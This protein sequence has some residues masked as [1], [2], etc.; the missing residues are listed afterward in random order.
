M[1]HSIAISVKDPLRV[2]QVLAEI[3]DG[4]LLLFPFIPNSYVVLAQDERGT[5]VEV[6]PSE[7]EFVLHETDQTRD[8]FYS[9]L[10]TR[11]VE[12][13]E[14]IAVSTS[15]EQIEQIGS[16]EG[17]QVSSKTPNRAAELWLENQIKLELL[18]R[19]SF[20]DKPNPT[21]PEVAAHSS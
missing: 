21:Q 13:R 6:Y 4:H 18:P 8:F 1:F 2:A 12:A 14:A 11:F 5:S 3:L 10:T 9:L 7:T 19:F 17:W 16:R 20:Q 15:W